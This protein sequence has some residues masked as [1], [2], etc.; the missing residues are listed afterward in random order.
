MKAEEAENNLDPRI[1]ALFE[2]IDALEKRLE[3]LI[4]VHN[5]TIKNLLVFF[6]TEHA[7][8][9]ER[10]ESSYVLRVKG[11]DETW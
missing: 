6:Q 11:K 1:D 4:E 5:A 8:L 2:R 3:L 7:N 10:I 9:A